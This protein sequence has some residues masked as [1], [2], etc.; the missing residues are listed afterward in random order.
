MIGL[1][2]PRIVDR[3]RK[4]FALAKSTNEHEATSARRRANALK[5]KYRIKAAEIAA[6]PTKHTRAIAQPLG[7]DPYWRKQLSVAVAIRHGVRSLESV[8]DI[9]Y[10]GREAA[11]A[12]AQH[13]CI[14]TEI[15]IYCHKTHRTFSSVMADPNHAEMLVAAD[16]AE[17]RGDLLANRRAMN[18]IAAREKLVVLA[19]ARARVWCTTFRSEAVRAVSLRLCLTPAPAQP[20]ARNGVEHFSHLQSLLS[21]ESAAPSKEDMEQIAR[22]TKEALDLERALAFFVGA[23]AAREEVEAMLMKAQSLGR[24]CGSRI[25]LG[26]AGLLGERRGEVFGVT[27]IQHT[28]VD[29]FDDLYDYDDGDEIP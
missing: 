21:T 6:T 5:R 12:A 19:D 1:N 3:V 24:A 9:A 17:E 26:E 4:L 20:A 16:E 22:A 25:Y 7:A 13:R 15:D 14:A 2:R 8:S 27:L 10:E 11:R 29:N 28:V 23:V 18:Q